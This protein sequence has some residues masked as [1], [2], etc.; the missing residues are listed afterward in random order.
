VDSCSQTINRAF[1]SG[2]EV[3]TEYVH[4][5]LLPPGELSRDKIHCHHRELQRRNPGVRYDEE[6]I[7]K[8]LELGPNQRY[9]EKD[10]VEGY[11]V[12]TFPYTSKALLENPIYGNAIYVIGS[13]WEYWSK[14]PKHE[15]VDEAERSGEVK[16]IPHQGD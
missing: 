4:W 1:T 2:D 12:F 14:R 9:E 6:R 3:T 5:Q 10:G 7:D 11:I 13:D 16:K 8:A 15:L